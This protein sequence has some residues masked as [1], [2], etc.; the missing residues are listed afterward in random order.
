MQD[1]RSSFEIHSRHKK[2]HTIIKAAIIT[3][4]SVKQ[5]YNFTR[6]I[7]YLNVNKTKK[8]TQRKALSLCHTTR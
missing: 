8:R 3:L 7:I 1:D 2:S 5:D 4:K 6:Q